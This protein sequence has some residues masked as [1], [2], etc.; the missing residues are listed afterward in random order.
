MTGERGQLARGFTLAELIVAIVVG[1]VVAGATITTLSQFTRSRAR[2]EARQEA[3]ARADAAAARIASDVMQ[4]TRDGELLFAR[5]G[6]TSGAGAAGESDSLLLWVRTLK[7]VRGLSDVP[8]GADAEVQFK[9]MAGS[10]GRSDLWRRADAPPDRAVDA[11]GVAQAVVRGISSLRIEAYDGYA[12]FDVWDSDRD[13][14]PHALRITTTARS[15][16]GKVTMTARRVVSIDRVPIPPP[17][18]EEPAEGTTGGA[19]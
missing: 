5:V 6:V 9:L 11:G 7:P 2:A 13:G 17:T 19:A 4:T 1:M 15:D 18:E 14:Y 16:D 10:L 3:F 12:W 8:E